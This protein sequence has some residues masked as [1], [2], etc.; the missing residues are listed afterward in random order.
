MGWI[1]LHREILKH[2]AYDDPEKLKVWITLLSKATHKKH[3]QNV[4][5]ELA[6]LKPGQL[7]F[8]LIKFSK[9]MNISKSKLYRIIKLLEKD[10]MIDYDTETHKGNF[11]IITIKN[12]DKYQSETVR[13]PTKQEERQGS[14][15]EVG[16]ER[17]G[18]ET[19]VKTNKNVKNLK[20]KDIYK[21]ADEIQAVYKHWIELLEDINAANLTKKQQKTILT[22]LKK[23]S[24]EDIKQAISNYNEIYRSD[25][26]YSHNFTMY[27]FIK[28]G[29]GA[30]RFLP[31]LDEKYDG[32][33]WKDYAQNKGVP[34]SELPPDEYI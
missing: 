33:I 15:K 7:I 28:Q 20:N 32:D 26:Y 12:W 11:S 23:W 4:G 14:E 27:K 21:Y 19:A 22:K 24:V 8:G 16:R 31:G 17:N 29:N 25:F 6:K 9:M 10:E 5:Y 13:K 3:T 18:S 2:W 34:K 1:K 30:P